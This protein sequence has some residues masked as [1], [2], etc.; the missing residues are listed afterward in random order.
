MFL[1][2][3]CFVLH[4]QHATNLRHIQPDSRIALHEHNGV[5]ILQFVVISVH[6]AEHRPR[7][8]SEL[9][10]GHQLLVVTV[11]VARVAVSGRRT[12][13]A[14]LALHRILLHAGVHILAGISSSSE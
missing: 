3:F 9:Q 12:M 4:L 8:E 14:V 5:A 13:R 10:D 1:L 7:L 11:L 2:F 6:A